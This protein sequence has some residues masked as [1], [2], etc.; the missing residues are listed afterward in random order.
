MTWET[1]APLASSLRDNRPMIALLKTGS[2]SRRPEIAIRFSPEAL[3]ALGAKLGD[4]LHVSRGSREHDGWLR[5]SKDGAA[6][7]KIRGGSRR[8]RPWIGFAAWPECGSQ[9]RHAEPVQWTAEGSGVIKIRLPGWAVFGT[10]LKD[11][12]A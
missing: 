1:I 3:Q 9:C 7:F 11:K 5:I 10:R 2:K 8:A 6:G 12:A 4:T